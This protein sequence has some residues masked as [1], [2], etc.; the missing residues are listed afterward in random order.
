M[1]GPSGCFGHY[2][3]ARSCCFVGPNLL[4]CQTGI[5]CITL[6]DVADGGV[7]EATR[8]VKQLTWH[9]SDEQPE[10]E[11]TRNAALWAGDSKVVA[12]ADCNSRWAPDIYRWDLG[13]GG[14]VPLP[15]LR[16][17]PNRN[18]SDVHHG[19][20]LACT[21]DG[22]V[23]AANTEN[24]DACNVMLWDTR[25]GSEVTKLLTDNDSAV[26]GNAAV[27]L[28][29]S[30]RIAASLQTETG[31]LRTWDV[32]TSR[33]LAKVS[34][35][36]DGSCASLELNEAGTAAL[37]CFGDANKDDQRIGG[38]VYDLV[39][40]RW[41]SSLQLEDEPMGICCTRD[42]GSVAAWQRDGSVTQRLEGSLNYDSYNSYNVNRSWLNQMNMLVVRTI[43]SSG[44]K[45]FPTAPSVRTSLSV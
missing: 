41:A 42:F 30:G 13:G 4:A 12:V 39:V 31:T 20:G 5:R 43:I 24:G 32:R 18:G 8:A 44:Q 6:V 38:G 16:G 7:E 22:H 19:G 34:G 35:M 28:D 9:P 17:M 40:G 23:V 10:E 15:P 25:T 33:L 27:A 37:C 11:D 26:G 2:V 36:S 14:C 1:A 29:G 21:S 45:Q 3:D